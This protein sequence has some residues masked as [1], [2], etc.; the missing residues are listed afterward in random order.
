ML[1][2]L[3][4]LDQPAFVF[5]MNVY[6]CLSLALGMSI[7]A[8]FARAETDPV[9]LA[10]GV[11]VLFIDQDNPDCSDDHSR[12][13]ALD[14]ETP[15]CGLGS[16][17]DWYGCTESKV[18][19]SGDRV[20]ITGWRDDGTGRSEEYRVEELIT[21]CAGQ[22][23]DTTSPATDLSFVGYP[24][25]V[26]TLRGG[27]DATVSGGAYNTPLIGF[28]GAHER[29]LIDN[30]NF[31]GRVELED[32]DPD[33]EPCHG[34]AVVLVQVGGTDVEIRNSTFRYNDGSDN[35]WYEG[36]LAHTTLYII[37]AG[38]VL[39][40]IEVDCTDVSEIES[41]D[42]FGYTDNGEA[43][44]HY[45]DGVK[46]VSCS[47]VEVKNSRFLNCGHIG[48]NINA[49]SEYS[50]PQQLEIYNNYFE[51]QLHTCMAVSG[52]GLEAA[53]GISIRDNVFADCGSL[54]PYPDGGIQLTDTQ[55]VSIYNNIFLG[56]DS[57]QKS[58]I[59]S[60]SANSTEP[61]TDVVIAHNLLYNSGSV[62]IAIG[63]CGSE[64]CRGLLEGP[65]TLENNIVYGKNVESAD[66][67]EEDAA[68]IHLYAYDCWEGEDERL[69]LTNNLISPFDPTTQSTLLTSHCYTVSSGIA[70]AYDA[71][72]LEAMPTVN[73]V[74]ES[75]PLFVDASQGVEILE[76]IYTNSSLENPLHMG[77]GFH[78][79]EN[80]P[81]IGM[82]SSM[83]SVLPGAEV[84]FD[85]SFRG[86]EW[87][88]L[89]PLEFVEPDLPVATED[90]GCGCAQGRDR[91]THMVFW[92]L[93][94]LGTCL[95]SRVQVG[96]RRWEGQASR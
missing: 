56:S 50:P 74:L 18:L 91:S 24:G 23:T 89:G 75:D 57:S 1:P 84:D 28:L 6:R 58:I 42:P 64:G 27:N 68:L 46:C 14:P 54:S 9:G 29:L 90:A 47:D 15:W 12:E 38:L 7:G 53:V 96:P 37:A 48:L 4:A 73:G 66:Q 51:N 52:S 65:V 71:E 13:Q 45:T 81:A 21:I 5:H 17:S 77:V 26:V 32:C 79:G 67:A 80:S 86:E 3:D 40:N 55:D 78:L 59:V 31:V 10:D 76:D 30:L 22:E 88:D 34:Y 39:D 35:A 69:Q 72:A 82:G 95:G 33:I 93:W 87:V 8:D 60:T 20:Y 25:D 83:G 70:G 92:S 85:G 49:Y 2:I 44:T 19:Q 63:E 61:T 11:S 36:Y 41:F 43:S 94:W 16:L 62:P